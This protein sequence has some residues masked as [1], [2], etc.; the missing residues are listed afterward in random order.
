MDAV[1]VRN[2]AQT[3]DGYVR[4]NSAR[5]D[6]YAYDSAYADKARGYDDMPARDDRYDYRDDRADMNEPDDYDAPKR[7]VYDE[8]DEDYT[9]ERPDYSHDYD[10]DDY[11]SGYS[12]NY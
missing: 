9:P 6:T 4:P 12:G 8:S 3:Y 7:N 5:T 10:D 1:D 2:D 11:R